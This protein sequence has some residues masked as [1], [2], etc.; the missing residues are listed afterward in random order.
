MKT[1]GRAHMAVAAMWRE[2][3]APQ[4]GSKIA[5][6]VLL[7]EASWDASELLIGVYSTF[8][9]EFSSSGARSDR[10]FIRVY[11]TFRPFSIEH[12][13]RSMHRHELAKRAGWLVT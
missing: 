12:R 3:S 1:V 11:S 5:V 4:L 10:N 9:I 7:G 13:D 6:T 8:A 2:S